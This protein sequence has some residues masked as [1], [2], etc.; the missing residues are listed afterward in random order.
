MIQKFIGGYMPL[1]R[2]AK[3][4]IVTGSVFALGKLMLGG[5]EQWY[6]IRERSK[7]LPLLLFLHGGPGSPQTGAQRKNNVYEGVWVFCCKLMG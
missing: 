5:V 6:T 7:N 4:N 1:Y 3:G 2:D